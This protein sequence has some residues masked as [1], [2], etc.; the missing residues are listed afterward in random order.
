MR[1]VAC[2]GRPK[3]H[4]W[5]TPFRV[6]IVRNYRTVLYAVSRLSDGNHVSLQY[7]A[8]WGQV[9]FWACLTAVSAGS[10]SR[11]FNYTFACAVHRCLLE[12]S[13]PTAGSLAPL[14]PCTPPGVYHAP[15]V[16]RRCHSSARRSG[17]G[18]LPCRTC[19]NT[20]LSKARPTGGL[21]FATLPPADAVSGKRIAPTSVSHPRSGAAFFYVRNKLTYN[22]GSSGS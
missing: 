13:P 16:G 20:Q 3:R 6:S 1:L 7:V 18:K 10:N 4:R 2:F 22:G 12:A 9:P 17:V 15:N 5:V 8:E 21:S 14:R 11:R 19:M